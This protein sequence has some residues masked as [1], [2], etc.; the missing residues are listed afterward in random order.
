MM[1][2]TWVYLQLD[3]PGRNAWIVFAAFLLL[4]LLQAA[5]TP[6]LNDEPY[7]WVFSKNLSWGYLDHP[8]FIAL[9]IKLGNSLL[10]GEIGVRF[11]S[12]LLGSFTF[13]FL[14]R[15]ICNE[16]GGGINIRLLILLFGSALFVHLY[17][18]M[19]L[20]DTPMLFF[21]VLFFWFY[22]QYLEKEDWKSILALGIVIPLLLYSKYHGILII[23]ISVLAHPKIMLRKTFLLILLIALILFIPHLLWQ[24][25]ND[26]QAIRFQLVQRYQDLSLKF[27]LS[28][29]GEQSALT[30]PL[31]LLVLSIIYKP[32]N[33]FQR[34]LK[35]NVIGIFAFFF[36]SSFKG[37]V[38]THWTAIAWPPMICLSYLAILKMNKIKRL[39]EV[40]L[41]INVL[42][43]VL[44]RLNLMC[45]WFVVTPFN[46]LKPEQMTAALKG[47]SGNTPLVFQS[48][49]LEPSLYMFYVKENS[50]AVNY[51]GFKRTQYNYWRK[52][53]EELQGQKVNLV[54]TYRIDESSKEVKI[55]G[56]K[57]Y[58][59]TRI[60]EFHSYFTRV[61]MEALN[62]SDMEA[63]KEYTIRFR[64]ILDLEDHDIEL[65]K[66]RDYQIIL[67]LIDY[68][69]SESF[70][71]QDRL[72]FNDQGMAE[73]LITSPQKPGNY[74]CVFSVIGENDLYR[75]GFNSKTYYIKV[76]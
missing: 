42:V 72:D 76:K 27:I 35:W 30:G 23:G 68:K 43:V 6:L 54:T 39:I 5:F 13:Y 36:I 74:G 34:I 21:G 75:A 53:E 31:F 49:Y 65:L 45:S 29:L 44:L 59:L 73:I 66:T 15:I 60:R 56:A 17:S 3:K 71:F 20:P 25:E 63:G 11:F 22:K 38:N 58:F 8:P 19:A 41:L 69:T 51:I 9:M 62:L 7:Y 32:E 70:P 28:Y 33:T 1:T 37:I 18:F 10:P 67:T 12:I 2:R 52:Y 40:L 26:F 24:V 16:S 61:E 48:M 55:E 46:D 47:A 4:N 64:P 50:F 14:Y 57:T